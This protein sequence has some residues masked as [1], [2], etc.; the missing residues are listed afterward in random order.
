MKQSL[1][2]RMKEVFPGSVAINNRAFDTVGTREKS[3][4]QMKDCFERLF[5]L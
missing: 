3:V 2:Y 5:T 1:F 4:Y